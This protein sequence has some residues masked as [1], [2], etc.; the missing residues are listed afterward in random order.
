MS[1]STFGLSVA[2]AGIATLAFAIAAPASA[3][4]H[5]AHKHYAHTHYA[6]DHYRHSIRYGASRQVIVHAQPAPAPAPGYAFGPVGAVGSVVNGTGQAVG[7]VFYGAGGIVGGV[8]GGV[9]GGVSALFGGPGYTYTA[10]NGYGGPFAAPFNAAGGVAGRPSKR[11]AAL[12]GELRPSPTSRFRERARSH[13]AAESSC[14]PQAGQ[15]LRSRGRQ[16]RLIRDDQSMTGRIAHSL[17]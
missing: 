11:S 16:P 7:A 9:L 6:H 8:V 3:Q 2:T 1:F 13:T 4:E 12:L 10:A 14:V 15:S 17:R 5:Y